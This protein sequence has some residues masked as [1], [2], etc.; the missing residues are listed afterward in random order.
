[1]PVKIRL[2]RMGR[3]NLAS[4]RVVVADSRSPRSGREIDLIGWYD[5]LR[6]PPA[7]EID[8]DKARLWLQRG[9]QPTETVRSLLV[10]VGV[11]RRQ[12]RRTEPAAPDTPTAHPEGVP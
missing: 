4:Y 10:R 12:P 2:K 9:A 6:D 1:M 3:K 7:L 8:P 5:P 11:F